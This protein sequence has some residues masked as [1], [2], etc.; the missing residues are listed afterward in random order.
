MEK[1]F[2]EVLNMGLTATWVVF[3][4]LAV[5]ALCHKAPKSLMVG[6]WALVGMRLV[7]PFLME[8]IL[9]LIPS[10][11]IVTPDILLAEQP[12]IHTGVAMLNSTVN[13]II[14]EHLAP[15]YSVSAAPTS[16]ASANP[17]QI[18]AFVAAVLWI[19]GMAV[20]FAYS[21]GSY[22]WLRHKVKV[23][24]CY[25]DNIYFCDSIATP[26]V[27]GT[28]KPRIYLPSGMEEKQMECVI[29]HER[30][31]LKRKDHWWK[32]IAF[33][34]LSV[35]WFHPLLWVSYLLFS[36]DIERA[37]DERVVREME[38]EERKGYAEALV[39]CS[40]QKRMMFACPLAFG[41]VGVKNRVKSVLNYKKPAFWIVA[42]TVVA[43]AV[44]AVCFLTNPVSGSKVPDQNADAEWE[45]ISRPNTDGNLLDIGI[46]GGADGPTDVFI[47]T[48]GEAS[49]G[50]LRKQYPEYF[51][52]DMSEGLELYVWQLAG[53]SYSCGLMSGKES[54]EIAEETEGIRTDL[55]ALRSVTVT[56]MKLILA[57]Y[58]VTRDEVKIIPHH[59][60]HSSY[61]NVEAAKDPEGYLKRLEEMF[62][63]EED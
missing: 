34:L 22:L 40:L 45:I 49:V 2:I 63:G 20:M 55:W 9:S 31:H 26:F 11:S 1:V 8:S 7:C 58:D 32:T 5:R 54:R 35:Y 19:A 21:L 50:W 14:S 33:F 36:R 29:A 13:P 6:L 30:S 60:P 37:C 23:S 57:D 59:M 53:N 38:P 15:G 4:V 62:W 47:N 28:I 17:M 44:I 51:D 61:L 41:E 39:A 52:L 25:R 24:L 12:S 16:G 56:E 46:I 10:G 42:V 27:F 48:K 18:I 43:G 3:A